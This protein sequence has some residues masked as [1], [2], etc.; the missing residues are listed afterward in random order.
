MYVWWSLIAS[1]PELPMREE[2]GLDF[3]VI[4]F[5]RTDF[6]ESLGWH[7]HFLF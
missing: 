1:N 2:D 4:L 3:L 5:V 6:S 7:L